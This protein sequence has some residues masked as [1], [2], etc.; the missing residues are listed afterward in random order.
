[1]KVVKKII[2]LDEKGSALELKEKL[3]ILK[4]FEDGENIF[5]DYSAK[6]KRF[7]KKTFKFKIYYRNESTNPFTLISSDFS[8]ENYQGKT[9]TKYLLV[10]SPAHWYFEFLQELQE[11]DWFPW[12]HQS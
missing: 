8:K 10:K 7:L 12:T 3:E 5:L 2:E 1:M 11:T 4:N 6:R 9:P